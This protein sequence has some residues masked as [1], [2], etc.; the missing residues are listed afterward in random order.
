[1]L[2]AVPYVP[3]AVR[4]LVIDGTVDE[5]IVLLVAAV[6]PVLVACS[7]MESVAA[8]LV[9]VIERPLNVATPL[10]GVSVT[11]APEPSVSPV[12]VRLLVVPAGAPLPAAFVTDKTKLVANPVSTIPF[13]STARTTGTVVNDV[14]EP[15]TK[16]KGAGCVE[17]CRAVATTFD[18][19][20]FDVAFVRLAVFVVTSVNAS[21]SAVARYATFVNVATP[22]TPA[23]VTVPESEPPP[24]ATVSVTL[25]TKSVSTLFA[26]SSA[27]T[28][29]CVV[30]AL[31]LT[32][33]A[34]CVV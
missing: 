12:P 16:L 2:I 13:A 5:V 1:M 27:F 3:D 7:A 20:L 31:P 15:L 21:W 8:L 26:A 32:D 4:V 34:G 17:N 25:P 10:E 24:E 18:V 29:G 22:A 28:T 33:P 6:R 19:T 30:N 14:A 23:L 9:Y 11:V